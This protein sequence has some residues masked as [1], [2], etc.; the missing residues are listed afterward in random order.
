MFDIDHLYLARYNVNENG[1]YEFDSE[2]AEG[3]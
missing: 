1:G 3:L 2:S